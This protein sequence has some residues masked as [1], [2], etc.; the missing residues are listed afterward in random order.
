M[1]WESLRSRPNFPSEAGPVNIAA[2]SGK[3][4]DPPKNPL[5]RPENPF[6]KCNLA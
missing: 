2:R 1:G 3:P 5:K 4:L 6:S